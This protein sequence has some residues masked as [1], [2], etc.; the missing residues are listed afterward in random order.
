[1]KL[2]FLGA[3]GIGKGTMAELVEKKYGF[4]HIST[5]DI[6]REEM[7]EGTDI[8]KQIQVRMDSGVLV[9]DEMITEIV[10]VRL[11]KDDCKA[12]YVLDGYP[13]TIPQAEAFEKVVAI[14]KV[15]E[16]DCDMA[17][18]L[19]RLTGRWTCKDC[20]EI[21]H[22]RNMPPKVEGVCDTC[23]GVLYQREDQKPETIKKRL[24]AYEKQTK[25]L[26]DFY[27]GKGLL[28]VVDASPAPEVIFEHICAAI[29]G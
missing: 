24:E 6:L 20:D 23:E 17:I 19:D 11:H 10:K 7:K 5:G 3:P 4:L 1:M 8:G 15:I 2:I 9:P 29:D 12:G 26:V 13:R 21:Y 28:H 27:R 22:E 18:I 14:D 25:P 16:L